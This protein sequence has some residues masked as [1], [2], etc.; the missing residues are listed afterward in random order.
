MREWTGAGVELGWLMDADAQT[1]YVFRAGQS[2]P[3]V[4]RGIQSIAGERSVAGFE[5]D[6][7]EI[8]TGL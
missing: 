8:W 6:L 5:L 2:E 3:E 7:E 1:I 4:R